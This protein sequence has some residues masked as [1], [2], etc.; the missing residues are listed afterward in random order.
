[1][2]K[3]LFY[4]ILIAVLSLYSARTGNEKF[5][6]FEKGF[7]SFSCNY[8]PSNISS[9]NNAIEDY[10]LNG[11]DDFILTW[12]AELTGNM[13][14]NIGAGI[15]YYTGWDTTQKIVDVPD[16]NSSF[17]RLD[18]CIEYKISYY[19]MIINYRKNFTGNI[20]YFGSFS[21]NYGNIEL[22]ISQ[23]EGDQRF[24]DLFDSFEP[25]SG[26]FEY[27]RSSSL[28]IGFWML[29]VN[30]GVKFYFSD[31]LAIGGSIGYVYGFVSD[32]GTINY[33]FESIKSIPD[34]DFEGLTYSIS[35]YYGS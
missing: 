2:S 30:S 5:K 33:E 10:G 26:I 15:Q 19:G 31:R 25:V 20:E 6:G 22:I 3:C 32:D 13:N 9:V 34:L 7:L 12:G 29:T 14:S 4:T 8:L 21:G 11:F 16:T 23:D 24:D 1:M 28:S 17:I 35:I 18:R 27:N